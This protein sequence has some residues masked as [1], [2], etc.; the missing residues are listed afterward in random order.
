VEVVHK[1]LGNMICAYELES[2]EFDNY[3]PWSQILANCAWA[4]SSTVH[5]ILDTATAQIVFVRNILFD[6]SYTS[7]YN[8][9]KN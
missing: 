6:L 7:N 4:I 5:S 9:V 2:F 3:D 8:E 1:T